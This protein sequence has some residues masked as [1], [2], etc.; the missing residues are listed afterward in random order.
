MAL[1]PMN[2][3]CCGCPLTF[4][5]KFILL[6]NLIVNL[7]YII[8]VT[9]NI[10]FKFPTVVSNLG[11]TAEIFNGAWCLLGLPF[12]VV[13]W[14]GVSYRLEGH[15]RLYL[16]YLCAGFVVDMVFLFLNFILRDVCGHMPHLLRHHGS[17]FAC[18]V[19]R[20]SALG[21]V[22]QVTILELYFIFAVWSCCEDFRAGGG[23]VGLPELLRHHQDMNKKQLND[24]AYSDQL[25]GATIT[26]GYPKDYGAF[27]RMQGPQLGPNR[28]IIQGNY[29]ETAYP[30]PQSF[31]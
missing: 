24:H 26:P 5:V 25:F 19:M 8:T 20:I 15:L 21:L 22:I 16:Q 14:W 31:S 12:I 28:P 7:F 2:M 27:N 9:M 18:G 6:V 1:R 3:F 4:G 23:G 13:G 11:P 29:H 30:P 17:A 10:I